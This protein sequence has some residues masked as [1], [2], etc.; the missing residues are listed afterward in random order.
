MTG[1]VFRRITATLP[2]L[3]VVVVASFLLTNLTPGDPARVML[4]D[5]ASEAEVQM[6]RDRMGLNAPLLDRFISYIT[7][8][9]RGDFGTSIFL[10]IPVTEAFWR[11]LGPTLSLTLLAQFIAVTIAI[12]FGITAAIYRKTWIDY[13]FSA[14]VL[15]GLSMPSFWLGLLLIRFFSVELGWLPSGGYQ[16]LSAGIGPHLQFIILPAFTLGFIQ[17]AL[18]ARMTRSAMLEVLNQ[19][20]IRA[21]RAKGVPRFT[22]ITRHALRNAAIPIITSI[23]LSLIALISGATV[24]EAVFNIPGVGQLIVNSVLRRDYEVI[25]GCILIIT[26]VFVFINLMIDLLYGWVDPGVRSS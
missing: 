7:R 10:R 15:I 3:A 8:M 22:I 21:A 17:A 11:H 12:P 19:N 9:S 6:L 2:V 14:T 23:G 16:P 26:V 5:I 24:T 25:T 18:I 1:F 13:F 4:G 20:Y